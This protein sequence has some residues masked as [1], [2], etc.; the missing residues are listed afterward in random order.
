MLQFEGFYGKCDCESGVKVD[1]PTVGL[2]SAYKTVRLPDDATLYPN[3][4]AQQR[5]ARGNTCVQAQVYLHAWQEKEMAFLHLEGHKQEVLS[6]HF[7]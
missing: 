4:C 2:L 3:A 6:A 5:R 1:L 7:R